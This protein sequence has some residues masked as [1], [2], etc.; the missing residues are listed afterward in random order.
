MRLRALEEMYRGVGA[1]AGR[2]AAVAHRRL[3]DYRLQTHEAVCGGRHRVR[4]EGSGE[5]NRR[6][7]DLKEQANSCSVQWHGQ[8]E[9]GQMTLCRR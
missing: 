1:A 6:D 8:V 3:A 2:S 4:A 7:G 5:M 9:S